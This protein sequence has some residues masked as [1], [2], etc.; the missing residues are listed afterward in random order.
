MFTGDNRGFD[1]WPILLNSSSLQRQNS[2][3]F[4]L[5]DGSGFSRCVQISD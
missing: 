1:P 3:S 2:L 5:P 4:V